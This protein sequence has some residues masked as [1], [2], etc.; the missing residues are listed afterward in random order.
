VYI[1]NGV[2]GVPA[3]PFEHAVAGG[4]DVTGFPAVDGVLAVSSIPADPGVPILVDGQDVLH[5]QTKRLWLLDCNFF[6][7]RTIGI[8]N[9]I[10]ANSRN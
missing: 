1:T 7:Y 9:I 5:Y 8:S 3:V 6:R 10:L 2:V 4:L